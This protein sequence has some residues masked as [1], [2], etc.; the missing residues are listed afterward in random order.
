MKSKLRKTGKMN[1]VIFV[2]RSAAVNNRPPLPLL[3]L[4]VLQPPSCVATS[5]RQIVKNI[6]ICII[7]FL[8]SYFL[9]SE[10]LKKQMEIMEY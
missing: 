9:K 4:G 5:S 6:K 2:L 7:F 3:V 10:I 8:N 1:S